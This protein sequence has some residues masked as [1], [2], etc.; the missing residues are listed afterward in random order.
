[1]IALR[2]VMAIGKSEDLDRSGGLAGDG[3]DLRHGSVFI[4]ES[5]NG[6]DGAGDAR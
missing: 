6:E 5:L 1:M 4:V 2:R 3:F